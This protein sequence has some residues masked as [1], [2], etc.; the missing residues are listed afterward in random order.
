MWCSSVVAVFLVQI[1]EGTQEN[2]ILLGCFW[3]LSATNIVN[4]KLGEK[5]PMKIIFFLLQFI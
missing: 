5:M 3:Y 4:P 2:I 1:N